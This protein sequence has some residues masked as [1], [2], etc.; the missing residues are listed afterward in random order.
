M[1]E[2]NW[3]TFLSELKVTSNPECYVTG[4]LFLVFLSSEL[5]LHWLLK[6]LCGRVQKGLALETWK[7]HIYR[8]R[9]IDHV[10]QLLGRQDSLKLKL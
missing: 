8:E 4:L 9:N 6:W 7:L 5:I 2:V 10:A 3:D 1:K